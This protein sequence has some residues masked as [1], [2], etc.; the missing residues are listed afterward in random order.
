VLRRL[1]ARANVVVD[2]PPSAEEAMADATAD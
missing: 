2:A 1:E